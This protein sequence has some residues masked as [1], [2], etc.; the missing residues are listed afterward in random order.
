MGENSSKYR[1]S[2]TAGSLLLDEMRV[3]AQELLESGV[4]L[5]QLSSDILGKSRGKTNKREFAEVTLRMST[6]DPFEVE[7]LASGPLEIARQIALL[8]CI[9][10]YGFIRDFLADV[11]LEKIQLF[12][13]SIS[14]RDYN[15]FIAR[16]EMDHKEL[17]DL[18]DSTKYKI[19]Q[20]L[21]RILVQAKLVDTIKNR[22]INAHYLEPQLKSWLQE[23]GKVDELKLFNE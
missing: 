21:F 9:R 6:L 13:F 3:T 5:N 23:Q 22:T 1:F 11:V 4:A 17:E 14:D 7:Q 2:F 12:D 18:A 20:V 15:A 19:K 10:S 8:A 16:K